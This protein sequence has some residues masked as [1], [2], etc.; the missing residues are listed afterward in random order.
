M[1]VIRNYLY[2]AG[3]QVLALVL[4]LITSPYISRVLG[5]YKTGVNTYTYS[6]I[7]YFVLFAGLGIS[8]YGNRQIAYV[9]NSKKEVSKIF[10]EIIVVEFLA[11][12]ASYIF[13]IFFMRFYS[14]NVTY[15]WLQSIYIVAVFFDISWLFMG[16]EDFKKIV[17]RNTLVKVV[18]VCFIFIFIKQPSDLNKYILILSLGT[19][20]GNL[21]F[22]PYLKEI[23]VRVNLKELKPLRHI[24]PTIS[25]F[26]PQVAIQIYAQLNKTMLG[27]MVSE[28]SS[29]YY[30][31][32]DT[33]IK[34]VLSLI[35]ATGTVMLPHVASAFS[36]GETGKVNIL[37]EKSFDY[38]SCLAIAMMFG[39]AG[40][41]LHF[42]PYFYGPGYDPVGVVMMIE[43]PIILLIAWSN[44]I[45]NQYLLP[46][47]NVRY[48]TTS[49]VMGAIVNI[50]LNIPLIIILGLDG[51][52]IS[53]VLSE[54]AVTCYQLYCVRN[55]LN[56]KKLFINVPKYFLAGIL[57]FL[58]VFYLNIMLHT[59][60]LSIFVEVFLGVVIYVVILLIL[61][62]TILDDIT[63]IVMKRMEK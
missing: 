32:S 29:S 17:I 42:G 1:K 33:L 59:S 37:V 14:S 46:T 20:V 43:S 49:V 22:W 47:N 6:I 61:K 9:Q 25:F 28:T 48:Y 26:A 56:L 27:A 23:L 13:F 39:I 7:Q 10:Y 38:V 8:L 11:V 16:L 19:L 63:K 52:M 58:P 57:M 15:M 31:Y 55:K 60:I 44:V 40:V 24:L 12:L 18:T 62:P 34:M 21:T 36:K 53:T 41:S 3:Y 4:P 5:P 45:G 30:N 2:N 51:A 50:I 54:L 35:T